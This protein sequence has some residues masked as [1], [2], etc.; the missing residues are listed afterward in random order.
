[1]ERLKLTL[2]RWFHIVFFNAIWVF[3]PLWVLRRAYSDIRD[4]FR[5]V[6]RTRGE[7]YSTGNVVLHDEKGSS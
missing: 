6:E 7:R 1:M 4:T 2:K 3:F 5:F